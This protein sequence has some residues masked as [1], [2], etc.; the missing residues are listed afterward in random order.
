MDT[1]S[2]CGPE[3]LTEEKRRQARSALTKQTRTLVEAETLKFL[4]KHKVQLPM[5]YLPAVAV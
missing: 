1:V 5:Y 2:V 3:A 4:H